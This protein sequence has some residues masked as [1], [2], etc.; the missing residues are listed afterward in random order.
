VENPILEGRGDL[1][2]LERIVIRRGHP[3]HITLGIV[4][5]LDGTF[6]LPSRFAKRD[7]TRRPTCISRVGQKRNAV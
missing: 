1:T 4:V 5:F 3:R 2:Y 7:G 6:R